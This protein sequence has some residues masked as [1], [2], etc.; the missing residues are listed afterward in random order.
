MFAPRNIALHAEL[1]KEAE[2]K[3]A[4]SNGGA[5]ALAGGSG[6]A[7]LAAFG[8]GGYLLRRNAEKEKRRARNVAFGAGMA[9]GV[10]SPILLK[11]L[12]HIANERGL[13]PPDALERA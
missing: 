5:L 9:T 8:G 10:A 4:L 6:L 2:E 11:K 3:V 13:I 7:G 12:L 1:L